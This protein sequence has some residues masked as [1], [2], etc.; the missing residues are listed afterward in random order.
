MCATRSGNLGTQD[1]SF[2][3]VACNVNEVLHGA[4]FVRHLAVSCCPHDFSIPK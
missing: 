4:R 3:H 2:I 1:F